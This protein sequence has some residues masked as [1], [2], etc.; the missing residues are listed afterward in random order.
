MQRMSLNFNIISKL[1]FIV[2]LNY[3]HNFKSKFWNVMHK[4]NIQQTK[5]FQG[6]TTENIKNMF[7]SINAFI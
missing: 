7:A 6:Q 2:P 1:N 4:G 5:H 3:D